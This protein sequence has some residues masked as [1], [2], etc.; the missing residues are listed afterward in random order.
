[1]ISVTVVATVLVAVSTERRPGRGPG[2]AE[3]MAGRVAA[4]I[5]AAQRALH[6]AKKGAARLA[7]R[8]TSREQRRQSERSEHGSGSHVVVDTL[9]RLQPGPNR[10]HVE[11]KRW[12]ANRSRVKNQSWS[13]PMPSSRLSS[14]LPFLGPHRR[15]NRP[16]RSSLL[17][18]CDHERRSRWP[19]SPPTRTR[20]LL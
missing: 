20:E 2:S 14:R 18:S 3:R 16:Q 1:M 17:A 13:K 9:R 7:K 15:P 10:R 6:V 4:I 8:P 12:L 19:T 11:T 5:R